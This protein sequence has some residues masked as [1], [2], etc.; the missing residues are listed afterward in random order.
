MKAQTA[1]MLI[2]LSLA[3]GLPGARGFDLWDAWQAARRHS[4]QYRAAEHARNAAHEAEK[5]GKAQL[6]PQVSASANYSNQP[7]SGYD[8]YETHGWTLELSQALFD[9]SKWERYQAGKLGTRVADS[10]FQ[11][12]DATLLL[13]VAK[14]YL[15]ILTIKDKLAAVA[16]EKAA[17]QAQIDRARAMFRSG[18]ATV[19]D[20]YEA[21]SGY[22]GAVARAVDLDTQLL[23]AQ[24]TLENATGLDPRA[25]EPV[26]RQIL[27]DWLETTSERT[28]LE[29][30]LTGNPE[31]VTQRLKLEQSQ[32]ELSA[33]Q[34]RR[35]PSL[36]LNT[37]YQ[38]MRND[39]RYASGA[40]VQNRGRGAYIGLR[41]VLPLYSGGDNASRIRQAEQRMREN[42]EL[43]EN[44]R[45]D[46]SLQVRQAYAQMRGKKIQ[47]RA[48]RRLLAT[49]EAKLASTRLGRRVGVRS[50]LD[51][52]KARQDKAS[53]EEQLAEARYGYVEAYLHLLE[54]C[55]ALGK[56]Q[57]RDAVLSL[58]GRVLKPRRVIDA[59]KTQRQRA[60]RRTKALPANGGYSDYAVD[61]DLNLIPVLRNQP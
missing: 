18:A 39:I 40:D 7:Q 16:A 19:I 44:I 33:Y 21:Q 6:L 28:W 30:A 4:P 59:E 8:K 2:V 53:A 50:T 32:R 29:Q 14:A 58:F 11:N 13:E 49:N 61:I 60:I 51:E 26:R 31:L 27:P 15:D 54:A 38:D 23:R 36:T 25:I 12:S 52:I 10:D 41:F 35:W 56:A 5:Q 57:G 34:G 9:K 42:S 46:I 48:Q 37:G 24:N 3:L 47:I 22:D 17:Y 45:R 55:G 20:T 43:L 1:K